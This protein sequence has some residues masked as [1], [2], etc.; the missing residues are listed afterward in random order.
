MSDQTRQ[1]TQV[2]AQAQ[3]KPAM[4]AI[5]TG[6]SSGIGE[7]TARRLAREPGASLVLVARR[8][9]RLRALAQSLGESRV[10]WVAVDLLDE[11]VVKTFSAITA[12]ARAHPD[13]NARH[14][15]H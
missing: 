11:S 9:K 14:R 4:V 5:V 1:A 10:S 6:A 15:G 13:G 2:Q 3:T 12:S 7:A 8:E